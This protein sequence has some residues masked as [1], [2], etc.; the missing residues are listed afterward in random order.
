MVRRSSCQPL[1]SF[2]SCYDVDV[3]VYSGPVLGAGGRPVEV[4]VSINDRDHPFRLR[5]HVD[6]LSGV[7]V[8]VSKRD[9][10]SVISPLTAVRVVGDTDDSVLSEYRM[11][12]LGITWYVG[13]DDFEVAQSSVLASVVDVNDTQHFR[14]VVRTTSNVYYV[15]PVS[16]YPEVTYKTHFCYLF[17]CH[18]VHVGLYTFSLVV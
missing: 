11:H 8:D 4:Q 17:S 12:E 14:A 6:D 18:A 13:H 3:P 10:S 2:L 15:Q 16:D 7:K 9:W 1:G 5:L